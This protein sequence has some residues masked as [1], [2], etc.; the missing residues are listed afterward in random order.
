MIIYCSCIYAHKT[1]LRLKRNGWHCSF[2]AWITLSYK[3]GRLHWQ[4]QNTGYHQPFLSCNLSLPAPYCLQ[5]K[6]NTYLC[7]I[8][9]H[10]HNSISRLYVL[11]YTF[12]L[13]LLT[14]TI[15]A[16]EHLNIITVVVWSVYLTVWFCLM[17]KIVGFSIQISCEVQHICG[18]ISSFSILHGSH[19]IP[20][21]SSFMDLYRHPRAPSH[22]VVINSYEFWPCKVLL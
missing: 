21:I 15:Q 20:L 10:F 3:Q 18:L 8:S 16:R 5:V 6:S 2:S 11:A 14:A 9:S 1:H 13:Y 7:P 17:S 4:G 12:I 22:L 19:N